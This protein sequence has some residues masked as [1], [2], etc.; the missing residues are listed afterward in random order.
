M[1]RLYQPSWIY[2]EQNLNNE[3]FFTTNKDCKNLKKIKMSQNTS[4]D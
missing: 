3:V 1:K 2:L 4:I